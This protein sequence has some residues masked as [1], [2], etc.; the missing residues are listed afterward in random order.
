MRTR[1]TAWK[2][3]RSAVLLFAIQ[4]PL[5]LGTAQGLAR[6]R[7]LAQRVK[8]IVSINSFARDRFKSRHGLSAMR[9]EHPLPSLNLGENSAG[10][11]LE[12][13]YGYFLHG[14]RASRPNDKTKDGA[15]LVADFVDCGRPRRGF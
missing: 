3:R 13:A 6:R 1:G 4:D 10:I 2:L 7:Q 9:K 5:N 11:A 15:R 14:P 8:G 12:I